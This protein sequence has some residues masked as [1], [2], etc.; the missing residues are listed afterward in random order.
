MDPPLPLVGGDIRL[1]A[2]I[3]EKD[4]FLQA[5]VETLMIQLDTPLLHAIVAGGEDEFVRNARDQWTGHGFTKG[6]YQQAY[7]TLQTKSRQQ[8]MGARG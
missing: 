6:D 3:T 8:F 4:Q 2:G 7:R 1:P 5:A